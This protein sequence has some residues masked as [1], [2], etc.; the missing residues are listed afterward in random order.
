MT[1]LRRNQHIGIKE[2]FFL[3]F[4]F[5]LLFRATS[6]AHGGSQARGLT[7]CQPMP[8]PQQHGIWAPYVTYTTAHSNARSLTCWVRP[9]IQPA[10]SWFLVGLVSVAQQW[11]LQRVLLDR[12]R[13]FKRGLK[14]KSVLTFYLVYFV[15]AICMQMCMEDSP[16]LSNLFNLSLFCPP[17]LQEKQCHSFQAQFLCLTTQFHKNHS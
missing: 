1:L 8:Q 5:F 6:V 13:W 7:S 11:E 15:Y 3:S 17:L 12:I 10:T 9:G 4:F 16:C 14:R 2:C